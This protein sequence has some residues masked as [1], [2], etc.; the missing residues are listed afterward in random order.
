VTRFSL[1]VV[2]ALGFACSG[3]AA[4]EPPYD[5]LPFAPPGALQGRIVYQTADGCEFRAYD[6]RSATDSRLAAAECREPG[7]FSWDG[8]LSAARVGGGGERVRV[9]DIQTGRRLWLGPRRR[10]QA[11][12]F[13]FPLFFSPDSTRLAYCTIVGRGVRTIVADA[14]TGAVRG[15]FRGTCAVAYTR[16]G[17]AAVRGGR[18]VL[19]SRTLY[20]P[21]R[22]TRLAPGVGTAMASN[23]AGSLLAVAVRHSQRIVELV[24]VDLAGRVRG[25]YRGNVPIPLSPQRLAPGGSSAVVWW[26]CILQLAPFDRPSGT[27]GLLYGDESEPITYPA[28]SPGGRYAVMAR[29]ATTLAPSEPPPPPPVV[30][31]DGRTFAPLYRLPFAASSVAWVAE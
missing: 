25:R 12:A 23:P 17:L 28:Y 6:L 15:R 5:L 27:F 26:G 31:F 10:G 24:V 1:V 7:V 8:R 9:L 30:V 13:S 11:K 19:R 3:A 16:H 14:R 21:P 29:V 22:G 20:R 4:Q 18:V 2:L